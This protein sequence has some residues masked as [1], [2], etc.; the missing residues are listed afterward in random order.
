MGAM[1][2]KN[3]AREWLLFN[4]PNARHEHPA[5][6]QEVERLTAYGAAIRQQLDAARQEIAELERTTVALHD[7]RARESRDLEA[8]ELELITVKEEKRIAEEQYKCW[9]ERPNVR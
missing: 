7:A 6:E 3:E 1:T 8:A 2:D 4:Y 9:K 5:F